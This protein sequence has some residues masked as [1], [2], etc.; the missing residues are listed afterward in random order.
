[1]RVGWVFCRFQFRRLGAMHSQ[2]RDVINGI[3]ERLKEA[4]SQPRDPEAERLIQ[5]NIQRQPYAPYAM[6]QT[7]YAQEQAVTQLHEQVQ[8]LQQEI[9]QLRSAP[10]SGGFLSGLF[11]GGSRTPPPPTQSS[12]GQPQGYGQGAQGYGAPAQ[13]QPGYGQSPWGGAPRSGGGGFLVGAATTAM[14]VAGGMLLANALSSAFAGDATAAVDSAA[15]AAT[16][17]AEGLAADAGFTPA[18]AEE[19]AD[20]GGD[21]GGGDD[22]A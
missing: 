21:F 16:A 17:G 15:S 3:F 7:L 4:A 2:E 9:A 14:G 22:W 13:G 6:A 18:A 20:S 12:Y 8:R 1:M 19:P 11:G 5:E 10:Q